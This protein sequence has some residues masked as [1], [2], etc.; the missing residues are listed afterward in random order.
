MIN[1]L[2]AIY[3]TG[4]NLDSIRIECVEIKCMAYRNLAKSTS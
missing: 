3:R 2:R 1:N 4:L